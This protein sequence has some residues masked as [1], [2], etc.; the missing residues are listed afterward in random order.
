MRAVIQR[1]SAAKVNVDDKIVGEIKEGLLVYLAFRQIDEKTEIDTFLDKILD[2][3]IFPNTLGKFD[4]SLRDIKGEILL[5]SQ[6][7][8]LGDCK[9]GRRPNFSASAN[10]EKA[11]LLYTHAV[12]SLKSKYPLCAFGQFQAEMKVSSINE[13][14]V[15]IILDRE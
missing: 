1:V 7:T 4:F 11:S 3:R 14:P 9:K 5:V 10:L 2:L 13:G 6:F 8:L 12:K 15:T